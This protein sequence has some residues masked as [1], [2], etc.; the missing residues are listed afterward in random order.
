MIREYVGDGSRFGIRA[1]DVL[2]FDPA[3]RSLEFAAG[4]GFRSPPILASSGG[5]SQ[6]FAGKAIQERQAVHAAPEDLGSLG[7]IHSADSAREGFVSY[8]AVPLL[9]KGMI[10]GFVQEGAHVASRLGKRD[11]TFQDCQGLDQIS[12]CLEDE[13]L[14]GQ[15]F[16]DLACPVGNLCL[17]K[18]ALG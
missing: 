10:K 9:M 16:D 18:Q 3:T 13:R 7:L 6:A 8:H 1:A 12:F 17:L 14:K 4:R 2:L 5:I 15:D 11:G